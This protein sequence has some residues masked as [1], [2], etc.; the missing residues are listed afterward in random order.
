[1]ENKYK[2]FTEEDFENLLTKEQ[3]DK[4][5]DLTI[6]DLGNGLYRLPG[7]VITGIGGVEM[8]NKALERKINEY[9]DIIYKDITNGK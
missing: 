9:L 8:F 2:D 1:M 4:F 3:R 6:R 7:G 5:E